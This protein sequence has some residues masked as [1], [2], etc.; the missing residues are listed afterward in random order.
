MESIIIYFISKII[1]IIRVILITLST[2]IKRQLHS[3]DFYRRFITLGS[4]FIIEGAVKLLPY[5]KNASLV[6]VFTILEAKT[7]PYVSFQKVQT[8]NAPLKISPIPPHLFNPPSVLT[9]ND[10]SLPSMISY[11]PFMKIVKVLSYFKPNIYY[12]Y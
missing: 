6:A 5:Y 12:I 4:Y 9:T 11:S 8:A 7:G 1:Y 2:N 10:L 3:E